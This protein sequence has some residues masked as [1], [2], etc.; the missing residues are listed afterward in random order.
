ME[1]TPLM[2]K[3]VAIRRMMEIM[4]KTCIL[5]GLFVELGVEDRIECIRM[6]FALLP[7]ANVDTLFVLLNFLREVAAN[8][9]DQLN[10]C[11]EV[12]R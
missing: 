11:G 12:V 3:L 7:Q 4:A 1:A 8:A 2:I 10:E 5:H 9:S 6:L